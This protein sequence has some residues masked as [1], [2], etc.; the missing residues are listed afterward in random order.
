ML[1]FYQLPVNKIINFLALLPLTL[2]IIQTNFNSFPLIDV[3]QNAT[4]SHSFQGGRLGVIGNCCN[5]QFN[6]VTVCHSC[7][8]DFVGCV[9]FFLV[10]III[11]NK[12]LQV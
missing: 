12:L 3:H 10:K 1:K 5:N 7:Y 6:I 2:V 8:S 9:K 4:L 11:N